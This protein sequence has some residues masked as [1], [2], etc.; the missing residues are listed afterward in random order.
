[1]TIII[2]KIK[3]YTILDNSTSCTYCYPSLACGNE[4]KEYLKYL[5]RG[6]GISINGTHINEII[7]Q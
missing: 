7:R 1:M 2:I 6:I 3:K 5:I 4:L